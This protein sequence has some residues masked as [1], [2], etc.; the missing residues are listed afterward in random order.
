[1][2]KQK[3]Q[4]R[5]NIIIDIFIGYII[6]WVYSRTPASSASKDNSKF[7]TLLIKIISLKQKNLSAT[8]E[9]MKFFLFK[10]TVYGSFI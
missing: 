5:L 3:Q 6:G 8:V 4:N 7:E 2:R 1:M 10:K 9:K